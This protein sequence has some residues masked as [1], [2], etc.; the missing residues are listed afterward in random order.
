MVLIFAGVL[1]I[2]GLLTEGKPEMLQTKAQARIAGVAPL[3]RPA[4][5]GKRS[6]ALEVRE[7]VHV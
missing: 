7:E 6:R 3:P 5:S 4:W 2:L 1:G